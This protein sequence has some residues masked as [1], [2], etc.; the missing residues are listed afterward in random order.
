LP[1]FGGISGSY[2]ATWSIEI[3]NYLVGN[4]R[5]HCSDL[6]SAA[7]GY[8]GPLAAFASMGNGPGMRKWSHRGFGELEAVPRFA[9]HDGK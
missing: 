4:I 6:A 9:T 5:I 8:N 1:V 3:R 7:W 2:R